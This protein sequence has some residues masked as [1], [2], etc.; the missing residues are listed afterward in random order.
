[1]IASIKSGLDH[2]VYRELMVL[3]A[4]GMAINLFPT[5]LKRGLYNPLDGWR[6]HRW[7]PFVVVLCQPRFLLGEPAKYLRLLKEALAARAVVDLLIAWY[8]SSLMQ[9]MDVIYCV[10]GDH[11]LYVGYF[12]K[13]ILN[14]PL[15][16]V[17]HAYEL[18]H[19]P[20]PR[21]FVPALEACDQVITVTE[22]NKEL[23]TLKF[24][25]RPAKIEV[26]RVS[27]D[28]EDYRPQAKFVILIVAFFDERKGHEVLFKAVKQL[29]QD[30]LEVWVVGGDRGGTREIDVRGLADRLGIG[31]QVAFFGQLSGTALKAVYRSCDVFCLPCRTNRM[32]IAEGFPTVLMEAMACGRPV[33]TTRH[34]EIPRIV[35]E[36]L[37]DENDVDGLARA[38]RRV[39]ESPDLRR[40]LGKQN[41]DIAEKRFTTR[42]AQR[43]A[44]ILYRLARHG[45]VRPLE[46]TQEDV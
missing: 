13:R 22:Y 12:C 21:L 43:T 16:V 8:F 15:A 26:V 2:F 33:I 23:L 24:K 31:D 3:S 1:V 40:R 38:I 30:D 7:H 34:V 9:D 27:V 18:Y 42:N 44:R 19:N 46:E 4:Q 25:I 39:Y 36:I 28:T 45:E 20:N 14:K 41:R 29:G 5:K 6:V 10:F 32:G 35:P 11:K 37:V 17:L